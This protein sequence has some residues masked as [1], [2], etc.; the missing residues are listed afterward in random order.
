MYNCI[1]LPLHSPTMSPFP[2]LIGF[3]LFTNHY[4]VWGGYQHFESLNSFER[5]LFMLNSEL[6]VEE[7][8]S[9]LDLVKGYIV[10]VWELRRAKLYGKNPNVQQPQQSQISPGELGVLLGAVVSWGVCVV[11]QTPIIHVHVLLA[12]PILHLQYIIS[13]ISSEVLVYC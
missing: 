10:D 2:A 5:A 1:P 3:S 8:S 11:R 6:W 12:P 7:S 4:L 13:K 9:M